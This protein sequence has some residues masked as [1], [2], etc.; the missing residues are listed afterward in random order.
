MYIDHHMAQKIVD[1]AMKITGCNV[2]VMDHQGVIIGSGDPARLEQLHEG[3]LNVLSSHGEVDIEHGQEGKLRGVRGGVNLPIFSQGEIVGVV[4]ITGDPEEVR[5]FA[6]LVVMTAELVVEQAALTAQVQW[7]RRQR[8]AVVLRL[9]EGG[10]RDSLFEDRVARL[11]LDLRVPRVA[12]VLELTAD[13]GAQSPAQLQRWLAERE[14]GQGEVLGAMLSA[15]QLVLLYPVRLEQGAGWDRQR[16]RRLLVSECRPFGD[17]VRLA[18]GDYLPGADGLSGSY[19]LAVRALDVAA[20]RS[21]ELRYCEAG[22]MALDLLLF[23]ARDSWAGARLVQVLERL[24]GQDRQGVLEKTL[25]VYLEEQLDFGRTSERLHIHRNTLRYRLDKLATALALDLNRP[26]DLL[27]LVV[28][29]RLD[30]LR[31]RD[32]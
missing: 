3:A 19:Q 9:I 20:R 7:D 30:G 4:G 32:D 17:A 18:V 31:R 5:R 24:R 10:R 6:D 15:R 12:V 14:A 13:A 29:K 16:L 2:N 26:D 28:A 22:D 23:E 21:P 1:R 8:E 25:N 11:G 27:Q